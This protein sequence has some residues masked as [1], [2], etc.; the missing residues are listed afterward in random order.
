MHEYQKYG[1]T[2]FSALG[3]V[4][5]KSGAQFASIRYCNNISELGIRG[6][7]TIEDACQT[8]EKREKYSEQITFL[9]FTR[10][11]MKRL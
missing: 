8:H 9:N 5:F 7:F 2:Q 6:H 3:G 10:I 4:V 11:F 1:K